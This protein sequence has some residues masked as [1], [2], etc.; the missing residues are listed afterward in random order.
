MKVADPD[1]AIILQSKLT[2]LRT[3][4]NALEVDADCRKESIRDVVPKWHQFKKDSDELEK[5]M[6]E[7]KGR[8]QEADDDE[9]MKVRQ[10]YIHLN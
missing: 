9:K 5:W 6:S 4:W 3:R 10:L 8:L 7:V 2:I 1:E